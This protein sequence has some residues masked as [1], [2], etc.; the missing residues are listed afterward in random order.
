VVQIELKRGAQ[1]APV[2]RA[3]RRAQA[4]AWVILASFE[5]TLLRQA[6]RLAPDIPRMIIAEGRDLKKLLGAM[7]SLGA[8]GLSLDHRA[9]R[10]R[11]VVGQIH[12]HG[13]KVWCWTVNAVPLMRRLAARGVGAIISDNPA[14]LRRTV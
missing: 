7:T 6:G 10:N 4:A 14:L 3:I 13:G 9:L 11:S 1:V 12:R 5:L 8:V 2:V